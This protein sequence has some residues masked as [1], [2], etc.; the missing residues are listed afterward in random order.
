MGI[1]FDEVGSEDGGEELGRGDR[2]FFCFDIDG[3]LHGVGGYDYAV[4]SFGVT[5]GLLAGTRRMGRRSYDVS[6][7]PSRSTQTVISVTV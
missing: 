1:G 4:V 2:V 5:V 6:M 3:V 7:E